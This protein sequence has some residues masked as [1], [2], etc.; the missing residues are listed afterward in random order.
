MMV[1]GAFGLGGLVGKPVVQ[2]VGSWYYRE[3]MCFVTYA[4]SSEVRGT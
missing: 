4:P 2:K 1:L 3:H